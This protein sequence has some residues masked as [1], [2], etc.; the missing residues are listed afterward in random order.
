MT[1]I[2]VGVEEI[3][4]LGIALYRVCKL[5]SNN[6]SSDVNGGGHLKPEFLILADLQFPMPDSNEL[7]NAES[8]IVLSRRLAEVVPSATLDGRREENRISNLGEDVLFDCFM[9]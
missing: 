1:C 7:W 5:C 2:W 3:K 9:I 4:R 6:D 8:N